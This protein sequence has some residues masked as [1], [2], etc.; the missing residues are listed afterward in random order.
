MKEL[1]NLL[2]FSVLLLSTSCDPDVT[3]DY[4]ITNRTDDKLKVKIFGLRDEYNIIIQEYDTL[5]GQGERLNIYRL[6][7]L[8]SD[9]INPADTITIFDSIQVVKN[10]VKAKSDFKRLD[11]WD[12]SEKTQKYGGGLYSYE[13]IITSDDF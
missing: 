5:I 6:N 2:L 9:Y 4:H 12:Y 7:Y 11:T 10:V 13:L 3:V 1:T 8:S